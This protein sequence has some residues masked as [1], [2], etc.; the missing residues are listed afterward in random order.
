MWAMRLW[1]LTLVSDWK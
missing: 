1:A